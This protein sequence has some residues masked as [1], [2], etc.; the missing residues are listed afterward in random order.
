ME[1]KFE[2]ILRLNQNDLKNWCFYY[3]RKRY[4]K[5]E[6]LKTKDYLYA[7]GNI[8]VLLV[9]HLDIV[10]EEMPKIIVYDKEQKILWSP[11]GI[12]GDDRC[13]VYAIL[14]IVKEF[15]PYVLFTTEEEK[16]GL[17][18]REFT[19]QISTLPVN[20]IIELDRR[21]NGQAVFYDCGNKEFKEYILSFGFEEK[22]GSYSDVRTLSV[23]YDIA[24]CNLS[25]GYYNEHTTTEHIY[26]EHLQNTINKVKQILLDRD[27]HKFYNCQ[28]PDYKEYNYNYYDDYYDYEGYEYDGYIWKYDKKQK[29]YIKKEKAK[30]IEKGTID[31]LLQ[32]E[33]DYY[34]LT[35]DEY[36]EKYKEDKPKDVLEIWGVKGSDDLYVD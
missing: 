23:E 34:S 4:K 32:K 2:K 30:E 33:E 31:Y 13:G 36:K 16:G 12:G 28:K 7:K 17:G 15:K 25:A 21:G 5:K 27:N 14:K 19:K 10:H 1:L 20:F 9:A 18:A 11:T 26:L 35:N 3:L 29:R 22:I 8:P 24:G 6:V